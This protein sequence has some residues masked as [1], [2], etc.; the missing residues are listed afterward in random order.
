MKSYQL[1]FA[2]KSLTASVSESFVAEM[3]GDVPIL[4]G[5]KRFDLSRRVELATG[6]GNATQSLFFPSEPYQIVGA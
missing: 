5:S 2:V 6:S 1:T 4:N 3:Y